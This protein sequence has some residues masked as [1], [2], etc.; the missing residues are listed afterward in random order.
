MGLDKTSRR[1]MSSH[2][3]RN[4]SIALRTDRATVRAAWSG[5]VQS[6]GP[7]ATWY[8]KLDSIEESPKT[9]T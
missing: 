3:H 4:P 1:R 6:L 8:E 5:W 9:T 7:L 2:F